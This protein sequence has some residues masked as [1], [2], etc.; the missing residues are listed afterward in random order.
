[1]SSSQPGRLVPSRHGR[2]TQAPGCG[3]GGAVIGGTVIGN[4]VIGGVVNRSLSGSGTLGR[5]G[6]VVPAYG[7]PRPAV[8]S[9]P[10]PA[11]P[12]AFGTSWPR[13]S[14]PWTDGPPAAGRAVVAT[15]HRANSRRVSRI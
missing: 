8:V 7:I 2:P 12:P 1:M 13:A 14:A 6:A 15:A 11:P 9:S 10:W 5:S 4:V 3:S